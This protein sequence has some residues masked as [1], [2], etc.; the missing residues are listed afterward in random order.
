M[1]PA[2]VVL[3]KS[4]EYVKHVGRLGLIVSGK[5]APDLPIILARFA[6]AANKFQRGVGRDLTNR[7]GIL[8]TSDRGA[9]PETTLTIF[10]N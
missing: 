8:T 4:N 5:P 1:S 3:P 10:D 9:C 6:R 7:D 2:L